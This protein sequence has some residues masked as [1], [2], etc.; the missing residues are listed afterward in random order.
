MCA[1]PGEDRLRGLANTSYVIADE[2]FQQDQIDQIPE[3]KIRPGVRP[4]RDRVGLLRD[5]VAERDTTDLLGTVQR[6]VGDADD[7]RHESE[8]HLHFEA[9][10]AGVP[11]A[12]SRSRP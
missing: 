11:D 6:E 1:T 3:P 5:L 7:D 2:G 10:T 12:R 9:A 8:A 4:F